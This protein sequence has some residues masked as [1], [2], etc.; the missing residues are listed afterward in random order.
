M[1]R[2]AVCRDWCT[3]S[4]ASTSKTKT[5]TVTKFKQR[6]GLTF[7]FFF[8]LLRTFFYSVFLLT[9]VHKAEEYFAEKSSA[10]REYLLFGVQTASCPTSDNLEGRFFVEALPSA[11][12]NPQR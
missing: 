1:I 10:P 9:L 11:L 6:V 7:F 5:A 2:C 3:S 4:G 12:P 8:P